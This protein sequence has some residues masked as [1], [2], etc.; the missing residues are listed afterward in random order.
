MKIL[1]C[2]YREWG[3]KVTQ[4]LTDLFPAHDFVLC[5]NLEELSAELASHGT[6]DLILAIGWSWI[7]KADII[8]STWVIGVH[9]SDL[10]DYGGGSPLQNQILDGVVET[11]NTL[12]RLAP[13]IDDGPIIA[14]LPLNLDGHM[15]DIFERLASTSITLF[16]NFIRAFP[17]H[18]TTI[19]QKHKAGSKPLR[20]LKPESGRLMAE[21]FNKMTSRQLYDFIRCREDPYPN[22]YFEDETGKLFFSRV[23]WE[24]KK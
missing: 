14:K 9:P 12:F 17:D 4:A 19:Q 3:L 2:A 22:V 6:P 24:P 8:T 21:N 23:E 15:A 10:P 11:K 7:F 13:N 16:A 18:V 5:K 20:R 1:C